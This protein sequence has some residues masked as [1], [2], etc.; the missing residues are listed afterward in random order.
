MSFQNSSNL[1]VENLKQ[2]S[3]PFKPFT[4][5][6]IA[7]VAIVIIQSWKDT[8][9]SFS[10]LFN[11]WDYMLSYISGNPQ[12]QGSSYFPPNTESKDI[13][14]YIKSIIE[15][16]QM[17]IIAIVISIVL[18]VP[19]SYMSSR[20]ILEILIPG[21]GI[22]HKGVKKFI[23]FIAT[24]IA[25]ICRSINEV[26]WALIFVSAVGLGPMAGILALG[27]HTSGVLS[28]LLSEG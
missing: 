28:K 15:T 11:G 10:A 17:A 22:I 19:L 26:V 25:N 21:Q 24:L 2:G 8:Q 1:S 5:F 27:I 9:M 7:V 16:V 13:I 23:Y 12:I 14:K 20:N 3:T 6:V 4:L 18:A